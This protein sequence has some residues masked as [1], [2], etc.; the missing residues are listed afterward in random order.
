[1]TGGAPRREGWYEFVFL[2]CCDSMRGE[3]KRG[4]GIV[5]REQI[6]SGVQHR[7]VLVDLV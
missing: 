4:M 7:A 5:A 3:E 2:R 1:M 6:G